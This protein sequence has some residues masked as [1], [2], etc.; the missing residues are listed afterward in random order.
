MQPACADWIRSINWRERLFNLDTVHFDTSHHRDIFLSPPP[1]S[2]PKSD[3]GREYLHRTKHP[4]DPWSSASQRA[5]LRS[6]CSTTTRCR[7]SRQ[8]TRADPPSPTSQPRK[9]ITFTDKV[10]FDQAGNRGR[11]KIEDARRYTLSTRL[12]SC[13]SNSNDTTRQLNDLSDHFDNYRL[14]PT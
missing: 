11:K 13:R 3:L 8:E 6:P 1:H 12:S 9:D 14:S 4:I 2:A 10:L 7:R 5:A